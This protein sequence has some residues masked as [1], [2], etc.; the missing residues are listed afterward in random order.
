MGL[1]FI[2]LG[3]GTMLRA[4]LTNIQILTKSTRSRKRAAN[5]VHFD[6]QWGND[7]AFEKTVD[8]KVFAVEKQEQAAEINDQ[9]LVMFKTSQPKVGKTGRDSFLSQMAEDSIDFI[10]EQKRRMLIAQQEEQLCHNSMAAMTE[11]IFEILKSYSYELNNAL[12]YGPL[13]VA[14][15]SPQTVTE[16]IKFNSV[17]Q[18]EE[19]VT[20]YRARL[21]TPSYS[22]VMRGDKR[23]IQ[24]FV[25][26]VSRALGLSK[27]ESN[28][29]PVMTL[30]TQMIDGEVAWQTDCGKSLTP[31]M[32][33][34]ICMN[35]FRGLINDTKALVRKELNEEPELEQ[36]AS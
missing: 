19:S 24:F 6:K 16:V 17:R 5:E 22:L 13:H 10:Q 11:H 9:I 2:Y 23:G 27:Q 33:E 15:T 32:V 18:A 7:A 12:G 20:Y 1:P 28:F 31:S 14:S 21:S 30:S 8:R 4:L 34:V 29:T 36:S 3:L 26:P 25:M 35:L